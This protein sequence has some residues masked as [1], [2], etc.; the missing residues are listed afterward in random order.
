MSRHQD[1]NMVMRSVYLPEQLDKRLKNI[2]FLLDRSKG[3]LIREFVA[4]GLVQLEGKVRLRADA[5]PAI[6]HVLER[7]LQGTSVD[8]AAVARAVAAEVPVAAGSD[9]DVGQEGQGAASAA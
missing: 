8:V 7:E 5:E 9:T 1:G 4:T 6:R 2:A 3:D